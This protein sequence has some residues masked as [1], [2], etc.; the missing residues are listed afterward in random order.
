MKKAFTVL[1]LL[2]VIAIISILAVAAIP[3]FVGRIQD[4]EDAKFIAEVS[5]VQKATSLFREQEGYF[6][7]EQGIQPTDG[8]PMN[9]KFSELVES[10]H[11]SKLPSFSYI[12][13]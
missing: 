12:G 8:Y 9:I 5:S 1:E 3:S 2:I 13:I 7:T 6:P 4:A 10:G 11:L